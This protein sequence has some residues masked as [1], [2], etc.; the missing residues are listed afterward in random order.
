M[1]KVSVIFNPENEIP[2]EEIEFVKPMDFK[3]PPHGHSV[4]WDFDPTVHLE[5]EPEKKQTEEDE[6]EFEEE[7][8]ENMSFDSDGNLKRKLPKVMKQVAVT[9]FK[10]WLFID[11]SRDDILT[12]I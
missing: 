12:M 3:L 8:V 1:F 2:M 9:L 11:P 7:D 4:E 10:R 5:L 6:E